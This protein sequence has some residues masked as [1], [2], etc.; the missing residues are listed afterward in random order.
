[1]PFTIVTQGSFTQP[2]TAVAQSIPLP[3]SADYFVTTN[4]TQMG[5]APSTPVVVK[6][7]WFKNITPINDG[8]RY[9]KGVSLNS[10]FVDKFSTATASNGFTYVAAPPQ[11][12]AAVTGTAITNANPAVVTMT[13][14][15]SEGD[16]VVLY[17]TTGMLQIAGQAFTI[18]TVSGS[19]FTLLGLDASGFAA[20]ATAVTA[21]RISKFA[22]V[23]PRFLYITSISKALQAVVTVSMAHQYVPGQLVHF[24]I[25][26]SMGM[27]EMTNLTG[28]IVAVGTYTITV[29]INSSNFSTFAYPLSTQSPTA[30]L[31]ATVAPAGQ[32]VQTD[33]VTGVQTGYNFQYAPFHNG[34]FTPYMYLPA[35]A[36][37][38]GGAAADVIVWQAFKMEN[39]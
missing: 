21:R 9:K 15:Y 35:G 31:F 37:S 7:E 11:P 3:S 30:G 25:P 39:S 14:T 10:L 13:N 24:M 23:E 26:Q 38:P 12:E 5:L 19:G 20:P 36:Q 4:Y 16:T 6:G 33:P 27:Q 29:D 8:L 34:Q 18:S 17:G 2:A 32:R 22:P 1:M 28:K